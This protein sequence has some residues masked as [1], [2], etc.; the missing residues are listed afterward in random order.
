MALA[1]A[2]RAG[3]SIRVFANSGKLRAGSFESVL[4]ASQTLRP[5]L[6]PG[7]GYA[8]PTREYYGMKRDKV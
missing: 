8:H 3:P 2:E 6:K 4:V 5:A 1:N 7:G